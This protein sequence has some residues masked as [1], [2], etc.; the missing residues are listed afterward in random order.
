MQEQPVCA[1]C[2]SIPWCTQMLTLV[3]VIARAPVIPV[4]NFQRVVLTGRT[5]C[6]VAMISALCLWLDGLPV[7]WPLVLHIF[8]PAQ[9]GLAYH[10][11]LA[12]GIFRVLLPTEL[13]CFWEQ[14]TFVTYDGHRAM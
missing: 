3:W 5:L 12:L 4:Y 6:L 10:H 14:Y 11:L 13:Q 1:E 2:L 8:L 9:T 7:V